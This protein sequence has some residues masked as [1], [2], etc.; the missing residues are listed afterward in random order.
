MRR[1]FG[2]ENHSQTAPINRRRISIDRSRK[3]LNFTITANPCPRS[4]PEVV[5]DLDDNRWSTDA[6]P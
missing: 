3:L 1:Q 2:D 6:T 5:E 4:T